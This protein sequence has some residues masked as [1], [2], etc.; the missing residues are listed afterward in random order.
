MTIFT[1]IHL[2]YFQE[3]ATLLGHLHLHN[4]ISI[5]ITWKTCAI[6]SIAGCTLKGNGKAWKLCCK[7]PWM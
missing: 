7:G 4:I 3:L 6:T 5:N 1:C 2:L